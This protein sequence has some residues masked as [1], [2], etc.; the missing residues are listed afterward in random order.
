[1]QQG[2]VT[3][4]VTLTA[5]N[6]L[7]VGLEPI[8]VDTAVRFALL[9]FCDDDTQLKPLSAADYRVA[10]SGAQLDTLRTIFPGGVCDWS[11]PGVEQV[12]VVTWA[13]FGPSPK[14]RID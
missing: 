6:E 5:K 9:V 2:S 1:M 8:H 7:L 12:P 10:L 11:K 13:S 4:K 14:N 3:T